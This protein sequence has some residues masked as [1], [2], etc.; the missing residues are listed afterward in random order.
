MREVRT[1]MRGERGIALVMALLVLLVLSLLGAVLMMSVNVDT[2]ITSHALRETDALNVAQA[3][4]S[5]AMSRL[6]D[7][8]DINLNNNPRA[9]AQIFNVA[10]GSVPVLGVDSIGYATGQAAGQWLPYSTATRDTKALTITYKTDAARTVIYKYDQTKNP[11]IQSAT[12]LPIYVVTSTGVVNKDYRRIR[13]EVIQKPFI[14]N[15]KGAFVAQVGIDLSGA[16]AVC[17]YNHRSDTPTGTGNKGRTANPP[18]NTWEL[19]TG[20][21]PGAWS[22][23]TIDFDGNSKQAGNPPLIDGQTGFYTGPWDA[24]GMQQAEFYSWLG[25]PT[26]A[27]PSPPNGIYNIDANGVSRDADGTYA[28][29]GGDGD[30]FLYIDGDLTIN[31]N[32][33]FRGLMF[34]EGDVKINGT[35]WVLGAVIVKGKT[36]IKIANGNFTVLYSDDAIK[37]ALA[38]YGGTFIT[39]SWRELQ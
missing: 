14:V 21:L 31:G 4:V 15:S 28:I 8:T 11:A 39:L 24:V 27:M 1:G 25:A 17:G 12:G 19:G 13:S 3:G 34:V 29:H 32:F 38:K 9:V 22:E 30:G 10:A 33:S 18:C 16:S 7:P 2:K 26:G 5:E 36:T 23:G 37:Q 6:S 35:T 20:D